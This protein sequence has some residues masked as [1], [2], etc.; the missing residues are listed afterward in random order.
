PISFIEIHFT[1]SEF[2]LNHSCC[3][4]GGVLPIDISNKLLTFSY[5][6]PSGKFS[7]SISSTKYFLKSVC[8]ICSRVWLVRRLSSILSSREERMDAMQVWEV[9]AGNESSKFLSPMI[10]SALWAEPIIVPFKIFCPVSDL[11][12]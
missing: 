6:Q 5:L 8:A 1:S 10:V 11:K 4:L 3:S 12:K 2:V 9:L 7:G